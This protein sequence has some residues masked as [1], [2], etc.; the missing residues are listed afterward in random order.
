[1]KLR[2]APKIFNNYKSDMPKNT[3]NLI[4]HG[5][6]KIGLNFTYNEKHV[7]STNFSIYSGKLIS[8]ELGFSVEGK[9]LSL[10]LA[11]A[12]AF[13]EMAERFSAG[14]LYFH[15]FST[16]FENYISVLDNL[17][18][19]T[20]LSGFCKNNNDPS[21]SFNSISKHF[22][23]NIS[24][25]KYNELQNA[26]L[27]ENLVDIYCFSS[28]NYKKIP[29]KFI[30]MLAGSTGLASGNT[31]EEAIVQATCEIFERYAAS[32]IMSQEKICPTIDIKSIRDE[33]IL[34]YID[35]LNQMN[36]DVIIKDFSMNNYVPVIGVLLINNN[37]KDDD[38]KLK[39]DQYFQRI[40][41]GSHLNIN[42]AIL[43]GFTEHLQWVNEDELRHRKKTDMLYDIWTKDIGND[44]KGNQEKFRYF[45]KK[46]DYFGDMSFL[47]KGETISVD[48]INSVSNRN[49]LDDVNAILDICKNN[50]WDFQVINCTH[51]I[52]KF[53]VVRVVIPQIISI[54]KP[55]MTKL[56][57]DFENDEKRF[58]FFYDIDNF[59]R[60]VFEDDW[61]ENKEEIKKLI[62]NIQDS[63]SR[64]LYYYQIDFCYNGY[65]YYLVNLFYVLAHLNL[66][67][68]RFDDAL[69]Y[70][71]AL[72]KLGFDVPFDALYFRRI[73]QEKY[74]PKNFVKYIDFLRNKTED[75]LDYKIKS[76]PFRQEE[77]FSDLD[78]LIRPLLININDSFSPT[79]NEG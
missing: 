70:F 33:R 67:L 44:Y 54:C 30:D 51:K 27:F 34:N 77:S 21:T 38:N 5:F 7:S 41:V 60:Y 76:N 74:T 36:F 8:D 64:Y 52:L 72:E 35:M 9:G 75:K 48:K 31:I 53:P 18:E 32:S 2:S 79:V 22:T 49:F 24:K 45:T 4:E 37:I 10:E 42:E 25:Q 6:K 59:Y 46:Y 12:S 71:Y 28:N 55:F 65:F 20:F 3:I 68:K 66:V 11:K 78:E 17:L 13:A 1:M 40:D 23:K 14:F 62:T 63:L 47:K 56:V 73:Y 50:N 43:R 69:K 57:L 19:R 61:F 58:N 16:D 15:I 26:G 29:I 39:K